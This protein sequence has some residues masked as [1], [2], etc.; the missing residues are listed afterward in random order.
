MRLIEAHI[1]IGCLYR[2]WLNDKDK[3]E[4]P[5]IWKRHFTNAEGYLKTAIDEAHQR[6]LAR[7]ELDARVNL[8]WVYFRAGEGGQAVQELER[9]ITIVAEVQ[10]GVLLVKGQ[11]PPLRANHPTHYF[12]QLSKI[13]GLY[14]RLKLRAF[15]TLSVE[16]KGRFVG[17]RDRMPEN[18]AKILSEAAE[19]YVQSL[20]YAELFLPRSESL[21]TIYNELYDHMKK[22][23]QS[24]LTTFYRAEQQATQDYR[25]AEIRIE[26]FG[27]LRG[28]LLDNFG[29][30]YNADVT[31]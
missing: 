9:A 6:K 10:P 25:I 30:Y 12:K 16:Q 17:D 24:E 31:A 11:L 8:A 18:S 14:G 27:L 15:V 26:N 3:T 29:D 5:D 19:N 20:G 2:D 23:N 21:T 22:M 1:E 4:L 13:Y 7:L 28:F